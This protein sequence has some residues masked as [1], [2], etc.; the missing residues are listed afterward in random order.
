MAIVGFHFSGVYKDRLLTGKKSAS[1]MPEPNMYAPGS[2]A[3]VYVCDGN[4]MENDA[5][6]TRIGT[7]TVLTSRVCPLNDLTLEEAVNCGYETAE[8]L[9]AEMKQWYPHLKDESPVTYVKFDL[10]LYEKD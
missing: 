8:D 4:V 9:R 1:V 10:K 6:E 3:F 5:E 7:A 2:F